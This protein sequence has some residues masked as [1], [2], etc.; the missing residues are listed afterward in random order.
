[1]VQKPEESGQQDIL[2]AFWGENIPFTVQERD[3]YQT[4]NVVSI[5]RL[6]VNSRIIIFTPALP[7]A[8]P[9]PAE[10]QRSSF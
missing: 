1:M 9:A 8:P 7:S 3:A 4:A 2:G 6:Y 5:A 10:I